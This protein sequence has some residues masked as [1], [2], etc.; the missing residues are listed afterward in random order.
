MHIVTALAGFISG[1]HFE[2]GFFSFTGDSKLDIGE[3]EAFN[4]ESKEECE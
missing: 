4:F 2:L 1:L 3:L